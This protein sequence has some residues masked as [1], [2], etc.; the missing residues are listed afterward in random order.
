MLEAI[1]SVISWQ[2]NGY[3]FQKGSKVSD[4]IEHI[5]NYP[6]LLKSAH[7]SFDKKINGDEMFEMFEDKTGRSPTEDEKVEIQEA[8][9]TAF[10]KADD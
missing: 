7:Y 2:E 8:I 10:F 5:R 6:H 1:Y 9:L 3:G 4:L